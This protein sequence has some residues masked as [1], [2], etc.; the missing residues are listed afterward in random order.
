MSV[1][2]HLLDLQQ[3]DTTAD[4]LRHRRATLPERDALGALDERARDLQA[5]RAGVEGTRHDLAREQARLEDEI[6]SL[7]EKR[8]QVDRQLYGGSVTAPREL[9]A[10]QDEIAAL[11]R[12]QSDLEDE[13]LEVLTALEPVDEDLGRLDAERTEIDGERTR[14]EADL[15]SAEADVDAELSSVQAERD[16][17]AS[18]IP[19]PQLEEYEQ[20]RRRLGGIAVARLVG[21]SCGGCHLTLSAVEIDR[22]KKL[23]A[24][25]P[26][27]CE[28]C[29]RLLVH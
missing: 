9:Q 15:A 7:E 28:E 1:L 21:T 12:R 26:A 25:Q 6:A 20:A 10:L 2:D 23:P 5:R 3:H 11:G 16:E 8:T 18:T 14:L 19:A 4:Q 22:I 24:D 13:L 29:G 17:L 27:I